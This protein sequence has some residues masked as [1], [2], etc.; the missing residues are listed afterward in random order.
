MMK[1]SRIALL[2]SIFASAVIFAA[3]AA[4]TG[5]NAPIRYEVRS[6]G[7]TL[8]LSAWGRIVG[9]IVG[10]QRLDRNLLG[11]TL[12]EGC[13]SQGAVG[14]KAIAGG[15]MEFTRTLVADDPAHQC[16]V[17]ERFTPTKDSIRW[18]LEIR[19]EGAPWSTEILTQITYPATPKTRYWTA[20]SD[21]EQVHRPWFTSGGWNDPLRAM[22]LK[23][24]A[25]DYGAPS[26]RSENPRIGWCPFD[27]N[28]ICLPLVSVLEPETDTGLS[29][30]L[31]P[32]ETSR[33]LTLRT[34]SSGRFTFTRTCHRLDARRPVK[35]AMDLV[36]H[37]AGWRGPLRWMT[38]RYPQFFDPVN[39]QA[40][41]MAGTAAY[42][43]KDLDFDIEKM[44]KMAFRV[45]WRASFDFPYMGMFL[46]PVAE[47]EVWTR[48]GG[49]KTSL[50]AMRDYAAKM[51]PLGFYVLSYFNVTE[52]GAHVTWPLPARKAKRDEDLWKDCRDFLGVKLP[53]AILRIP[54]RVSPKALAGS[55]YPSSRAG[56]CYFTWEEGIVMDCGDPAYRDFL[57]DQA[58][59]HIDQLP[60]SSGICI[61]RLDWMRLYNDRAD[62]GE[63]WFEGRPARSLLASWNDL[64]ARLGPL[65][66]QA[67][68][69]VFVNNHNKRLDMLRHVDGIFDEFTYAGAPLNL[70]ALLTLRKPALGWTDSEAALKPDPDVFFQRYLH[71]GVY[72]MAPFPGNDHSLRPSAWVDR[73]YLAYGPLLDAMRGKRWVLEPHCVESATPGVKVN[74]F[75]VPGGYVLP[76]TFGGRSESATVSLRNLPGLD[77]LHCHALHPGEEKAAAVTAIFKDDNMTL[78]VPLKRGCAMVLL[79]HP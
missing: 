51:R 77:Q 66:H 74:L 20:W 44:K 28:L 13:R 6:P 43:C 7:L 14:A 61:D 4:E 67:G 79:R 2:N 46:P 58:R 25:F 73:Q 10:T 33:E 53:S 68:K 40:H 17:V 8:K 54:Q 32:E 63:S 62:D 9:S 35:F 65:M 1:F 57:L 42:S 55:I 76:V 78:N 72:P 38:A 39:P 21:P 3:A 15:G 60:Q 31:S 27:G 36:A 75:Q 69:V 64:M 48:F 18:E 37:E 19:G 26:F 59:R 30:I 12:L 49:Q 70:T 56:G 22:P 24:A 23:D 52:F 45:N 16:Q 47:S 41:D 11:Q 29:L 34:T 71:L 50:S 5:G